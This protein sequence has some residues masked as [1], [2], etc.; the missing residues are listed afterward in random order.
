M[1]YTKS[2]QKNVT[3]VQ[4]CT[5]FDSISF[6]S[7]EVKFT[8]RIYIPIGAPTSQTKVL[9]KNKD[10]IITENENFVMFLRTGYINFRR[11]SNLKVPRTEESP[12]G[13]ASPLRT[14]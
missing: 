2:G 12:K 8:L 9:H 14:L 13:M 11:N 3:E 1:I 4:F 7:Q 5:W 10:D 6:I